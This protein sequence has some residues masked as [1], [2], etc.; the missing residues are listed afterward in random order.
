MDKSTSFESLIVWQK[1]H[2]FVLKVYKLTESFPKS[3]TYGLSNQ[4]R[5]ASVSIPANIAE[6]YKKKGTK[7]KLRFFN[8]AQGSLEECRYYLI[9]TKDLNY[10]EGISEEID[11]IIEVSKLLNGYCK[12]I[13][14][15]LTSKS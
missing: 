5:R 14:N 1:A 8:I 15:S 3:E 12:A 9:L 6:G 2:Q 13:L 10:S 11:L 4:F 7:D